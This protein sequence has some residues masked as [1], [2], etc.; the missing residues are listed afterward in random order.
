MLENSRDEQSSFP[1]PM[2]P[3]HGMKKRGSSIT[4]RFLCLLAAAPIVSRMQAEERR[5]FLSLRS[6][7]IRMYAPFSSQTV[8]AV[9][10]MMCGSK[11]IILLGSGILQQI[12]QPLSATSQTTENLHG[13]G[14]ASSR[15]WR[16]QRILWRAAFMYLSSAI[17]NITA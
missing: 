2:P 6:I 7:R 5:G 9:N 17:M 11:S 13:I 4:Q 14:A 12:L 10:V 1:P 8:N 3:L 15:R 16:E